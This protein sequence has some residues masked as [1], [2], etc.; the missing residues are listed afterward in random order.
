MRIV[1]IALGS[2][3]DVQPYIALGKGLK[4]AG[5]EV[6]LLTH[7]AFEEYVSPH[8]LEFWP[9]RGNI[10]EVIESQEMRELLEK[11]NYLA[12]SRFQARAAK[13]ASVE[14]A[15][16]GLAACQGAGLLIAGIGG[17]FIG[18]A[19]AERLQL[20][21]IQ[22]Y[23]VPFTPTRDFPGVLLPQISIQLGGALNRLTHHMTRQIMWQGFRSAD[24]I[25]RQEVLDL[26]AATFW[27]PYNSD[28]IQG[29]PVLH[30]YSSSVIPR[31]K[32][33]TEYIHVTGYWFLDS[34][35]DW[36]PPLF[37]TEFLESGP[38]PVYVG[39]G[40]MSSRK[41]EETAEIVI[42]ALRKSNQRAIL[43]SGW[44]GLKRSDLPDTI[45]M[46]D[47][48][49]HSWLF[50]RVAAVV[51]HG[52]AGTTSAGFR[53][54]VPSIIVP[55]F[56]DQPFWGSRA[57]ELAVGPEPIPR[58]QLSAENLAQAIEIAVTDEG[59]RQRASRLGTKIR[60]EDGVGQAVEII[61][62]WIDN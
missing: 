18:I 42:S 26:P 39:F 61:E 1:I 37:L 19:L 31:P 54:G 32:D 27:G 36:D 28:Q 29:L 48:I 46:I 16:D 8:G 24:R 58:K 4:Q 30:G 12:I 15:E 34:E 11:G 60:D 41:P 40:S 35:N 44:D 53:A 14:W 52:G 17:I 21:L 56:G 47:S 25:A 62:R 13:Q 22:A 9:A 59:I 10:Q 2:R 51:H 55:F 50:P 57:S 5:H 3:G 33:R 45:I 49:P 6:R 20:P 38:K 7:L 43:L 23:Y